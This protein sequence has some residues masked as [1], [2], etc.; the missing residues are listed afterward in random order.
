M[1]SRFSRP[2]CKTVAPRTPFLFC[3]PVFGYTFHGASSNF[4]LPDA[5][6][7]PELPEVEASRRLLEEKLSGLEI[8]SCIATEA[9][10]HARDGQFDEIVFDDNES[11]AASIAAALVGKTLV[12]VRRRGKQLWLE[13]SS[14]PHL[15]AHFGMTGAFAIRGVDPQTFK[16]FKVHAEEWPPRFTKLELSF[17]GGAEALAFC[18]PRRLGRLRLRADPEREEPWRSLAPDALLDLP[19]T[20]AFGAKLASS[21]SVIKAMLLDQNKLISGVGNWVADEVLFQA[22]IHPEA[23]CNTLS[24]TQVAALHC[25]IRDVISVAVGCNAEATDFPPTWLFHYRWGKGA[26]GT[27]VP[28]ERGGAISYSTVGGRTSAVVL[29][30]QKKG[31]RAA[32]E[33]AAT[34]QGKAAAKG[35]ASSGGRKKAPKTEERDELV[36]TASDIAHAAPETEK[37]GKRK[38]NR[39]LQ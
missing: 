6:D 39:G 4:L 19:S 7:M 32:G 38:R 14:P 10:G 30:R 20:A 18:D 37:R 31:E 29:S 16:E 5:H 27:K 11:S 13:M 26:N 17:G 23:P 33:S 22:A 15:L 21:S 24:D 2:P 12:G 28:G 36:G 9:G 8:C 34:A 35:K 1:R 3:G 25:A